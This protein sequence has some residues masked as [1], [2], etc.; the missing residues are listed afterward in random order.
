MSTGSMEQLYQQVILDH[1][2]TPHG[3][4]LQ[5]PVATVGESHQ[6]NP[7]CGD[8]VTLRVEL[9]T[10]APEA[11]VSRISWEGQGCSISQASISVLHDLVT[12]AGLGQVDDLAGTF[13]ALMHARGAGLDE[14]AE[15]ALGD[16]TAFTGVAKY[17]ARIKCALLGWA[18]LQDALIKTGATTSQE[19][20]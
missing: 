19:D 5:E 10:S 16:A 8:E 9:D 6:V 15:D 4:G 20:A 7:T 18:A 14:E 13:R 3:K 12:G 17:P 1:A 11:R 2:R